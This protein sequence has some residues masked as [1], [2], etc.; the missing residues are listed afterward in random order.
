MTQ[1]AA[2]LA[3]LQ[4]GESITPL[5]AIGVYG[6]YRLAARILELRSAGYDI[7]TEHKRDA[8]GKPY[9]SYSLSS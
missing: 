2:I 3:H 1:N 7:V 9:A 8:R 6:V 4:S 5:E